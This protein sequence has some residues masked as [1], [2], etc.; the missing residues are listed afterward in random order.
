MTFAPDWSTKPF[1][2]RLVR[3]V[4]AGDK[5]YVETVSRVYGTPEDVGTL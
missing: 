4:L 3:P 5:V 2:I 1:P